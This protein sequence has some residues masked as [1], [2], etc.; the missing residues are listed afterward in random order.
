MLCVCWSVSVRECVV[1]WVWIENINTRA[2]SESLCSHFVSYLWLGDRSCSGACWCQTWCTGTTCHAEAEI[3][4]LGLGGGGLYWFHTAWYRGHGW[5]GA[6]PQWCTSSDVL[7]CLW[8]FHGNGITP[9]H[10]FFTLKCI[11]NKQKNLDSNIYQTIQ[12]Y[13]QVL[14]LTISTEHFT[15]THLQEELCRYKIW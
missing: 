14:V 10:I 7:G 9:R 12:L 13:A 15:K 1:L 6:Q 3:T 4:L 5:Q 2:N 8:Q 11:P